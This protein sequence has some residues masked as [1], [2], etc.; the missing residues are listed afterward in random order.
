M[1]SLRLL[2]LLVLS[3]MATMP[4]VFAANTMECPAFVT[5]V[6]LDTGSN[7]NVPA[8][9]R[10]GQSAV[11]GRIALP[12][13]DH[14]VDPQGKRIVCTYGVV[15]TPGGNYPVASISKPFPGKATCT[16]IKGYRFECGAG[17][18]TIAPARAPAVR[19]SKTPQ[20]AA[21]MQLSPAH[22]SRF[23]HYP[24]K[25]I[26][27][28]RTVAGAASYAAEVQFCP[29]RACTDANAATFKRVD[30]LS[31]NEFTFN[32]AGA[33][34]GRWRVWANSSDGNTGTKSPWRGFSYSK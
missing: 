10:K 18:M 20:L 34:G 6:S 21:P 19:L 3:A 25:T 32:F 31:G 24:R 28:W 16:A 8:G 9:W 11:S 12:R 33:Q 7:F 27:R 1:K 23:S 13:N 2:L 26:L 15:G 14:Y 22:G 4:A 30:G 29:G 17:A 5:N